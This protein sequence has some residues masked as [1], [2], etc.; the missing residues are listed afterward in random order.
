MAAT[1]SVPPLPPPPPPMPS[2][3][4]V[5]ARQIEPAATPVAPAP[6]A[7]APLPMAPAGAL[8]DSTSLPE[9]RHVERSLAPAPKKALA[10]STA[11]AEE[12]AQTELRVLSK[13]KAP[14]PA[15]PA[16][17]AP[18]P[19]MATAVDRAVAAPET[20][21]LMQESSESPAGP[22]L[23]ENPAP[24]P[25]PPASETLPATAGAAPPEEPMAAA[26]RPMP[27]QPVGDTV[28]DDYTTLT[29]FYGTDRQSLEQP[30]ANAA[31]YLIWLAKTGGCALLALLCGVLAVRWAQRRLRLAL[32]S[33]GCLGSALA[34]VVL[35]LSMP[36]AE[37]NPA[38]AR[39][40]G[41]QR[42]SMELGTCQI[43]IPKQHE[44]GQVERP[45]ILHLEF[46]E[47]PTK[48]VILK[49]VTPEPV[50]D[51]YAKLQAHVGSSIGHEAFVFV[52]GFNVTFEDAARRTAQMAYDLKFEGAPIFFSWPSQGGLL[53]Y[54][55]DETNVVWT[56]PHLKD[57]LVDIARRSGAQ[58]V[59]LIAHSMGNR[60]LT[61]ALQSM[62]Y[63]IQGTMPHF[64]QVILTAPD[65]DAEIF[66]RDLAPAVVRTA[67]RVTLYAS[68]NDEALA[69]SKQL[70]GYRR[71]GD[72]G[73]GLL[74]IPGIDTIDVSSVDTSLLGHSYYGDNHTVLQDLWDLLHE[75]K[76]PAQRP[77]LHAKELGKLM[78]WVFVT[79]V[80]AAGR[81]RQGSR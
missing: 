75:A 55:V 12:K 25:P 65:I 48:H 30:H 70:H 56:V 29:V 61:A 47:D 37:V 34:T 66:S 71:A 49:S 26:E 60:A 28:S 59:H 73:D 6:P 62:T 43:T 31:S 21:M 45:S 46:Q 13:S 36:A 52:H 41:N 15:R 76:P 74:V 53:Q 63:E 19:R 40:Y 67:E 81:P 42:G 38:L 2:P 17:T 14:T 11:L 23:L 72:S 9:A 3:P 64:R 80:Q 68:S 33:V 39:L 78:Y 77:W 57:F 44:V 7:P 79:E 58:S 27:S 20:R 69:L 35:A 1:G 8:S 22:S 32:L 5:A 16:E 24:A 18:V 50:D 54:T 10:P 4:A 51:F